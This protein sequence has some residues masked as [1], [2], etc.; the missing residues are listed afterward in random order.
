MKHFL[1]IL[2]SY[3][4][5]Y[6]QIISHS[7][8]VD[9]SREIRSTKRL[10]ASFAIGNYDS[11]LLNAT[12]TEDKIPL[13]SSQQSP[14]VI[15]FEVLPRKLAH[16]LCLAS[17]PKKYCPDSNSDSTKNSSHCKLLLDLNILIK[18]TIDKNGFKYIYFLLCK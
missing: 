12:N 1:Y 7:T 15:F 8:S 5:I 13:S 10:K 6:G 4:E 3:D 16:T 11:L 17:Y 2:K 14:H 9:L 18:G